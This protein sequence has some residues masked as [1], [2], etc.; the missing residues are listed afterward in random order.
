MVEK[1]DLLEVDGG[2]GEGEGDRERGGRGR[3]REGE[4]EG[5]RMRW[6][7]R[8]GEGGYF[9]LAPAPREPQAPQIDGHSPVF[10]EIL[11]PLSP[12]PCFNLLKKTP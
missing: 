12:L 1:A 6:E 10:N 3:D 8:D 5:E 9:I 2:N 7:G 4:R 11:S